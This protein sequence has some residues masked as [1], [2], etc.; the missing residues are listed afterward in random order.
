[1]RGVTQCVL[2]NDDLGNN[3]TFSWSG[4]ALAETSQDGHTSISLDSSGTMSTLAI[5]NVV[6]GDAGEY[7]CSYAGAE[8]STTLVVVGKSS[9]IK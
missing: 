4:P 7:N 2:D 9:V 5:Y 6:S 8:V 3:G 1:M